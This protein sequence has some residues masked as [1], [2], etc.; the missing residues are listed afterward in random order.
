M[1]VGPGRRVTSTH[2]LAPFICVPDG[3][4]RLCEMHLL[5]VSSLA[6]PHLPCWYT[7]SAQS[8]ANSMLSEGVGP[9]Q[10]KICV[11]EPNGRSMPEPS[12]R[13]GRDT[14]RRIIA[15]A[16]ELMYERGVDATSV[17][18]VLAASGTGKSQFY[19]YLSSKEELVAEVMNHQ[20]EQILTE[21]G[22]LPLD[23]WTG[24]DAWFDALVE[25]HQ[26]QRKFHGCPLGSIVS[27]VLDQ[28]DYLHTSAKDAFTRWESSLADGLHA[29]RARGLLRDDAEPTVLAEV[30]IAILQGGYLLS[31]TKQDSR[32]MRN[33]LAAALTH[34]TSF[35]PPAPHR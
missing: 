15:V 7:V 17:E 23:T 31:S 25:R 28:S 6:Q 20:L 29:M 19:H 24:I 30:T 16:A 18:D 8:R 4:L 3:T 33:A 2:R 35:A 21:Q 14:K 10:P 13:R 12:T 9:W 1:L 5:I 22:P 26:T 34:L 32:P 27:Q 11:A